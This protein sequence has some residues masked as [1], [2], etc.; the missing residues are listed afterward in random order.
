MTIWIG[1]NGPGCGA[2]RYAKQRKGKRKVREPLILAGH[3]A[4]LRVDH[5]ALLIRGGFTHFSQE[6]ETYRFFKGDP[7]IPSRIVLLDATGSLSFEVLAWLQEQDVSL[8]QLNWKGDVIC[9]ASNSG[10]SANPFRVLWQREIR[11]DEQKR[12]E[13]SSAL[14][15]QKID[16]SI[17]VLEKSIPKNIARSAAVLKAYE[18]LDLIDRCVPSTINELRGLEANAA[19]AYFRAWKGISY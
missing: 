11:A 3:G 13:F 12:L 9:V 1:R 15:H 2:G 4:S 17:K 14:I 19:A 10:Y 18:S 16:N 7:T 8:V 6:K 5:G